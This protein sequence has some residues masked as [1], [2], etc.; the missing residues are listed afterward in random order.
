MENTGARFPAFFAGME[1]T[2]IAFG[3]LA[4]RW[5]SAAAGILW[6][7]LAPVVPYAGLC[8]VFTLLDFWTAWQ[9]GRRMAAAGHAPDS[10]AKVSSRGLRRV[11]ASLVRIY[12]A[13]I[14]A[15]WVQ[16]VIVSDWE[17]AAGFNAL[18]FTAGAICFYQLLS[19]LEN[20]SSC[21]GKPWAAKARK[22]LVDKAKRHL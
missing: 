9:L 20:E 15:D 11:V 13:L 18:K 16:R 6:S 4:K 8:T 19:I 17:L 21:S 1:N 22:Y 7:C 12:V 10:A 5:A 14:V 2:F 3:P